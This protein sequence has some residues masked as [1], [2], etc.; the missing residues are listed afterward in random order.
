MAGPLR[1]D[2]GV[3]NCYPMSNRPGRND[4]CP[5]GS[6]KKYKRCCLPTD[7]AA[8]RERARQ[9]ALF[10]DD[11]SGDPEFDADDDGE[12]FLDIEED[13]PI[14]DVD[15]ITRVC[16]TRGFVSKLSDLRSGRGVQVT[17]WEAPQIPQEVLDSIEREAVETLEG[18]WGDPKAADPIQVD[19]IDLETDT[20]VVSIEVFNRAIFLVHADDEE[21]R[22]IH[23]LCGVLEAA[24][25]G[26][27]DQSTEQRG[28]AT[29]LAVIRRAGVS[30]PAAVTCDLASVLK[31]HRRQPGTCD[32]CG[33]SLTRTN[34]HGHARSCALAHDAPSGPEQRLLYL[35]ATASGLPA[36]WVD[37]EARADG[38]L[39]ALDSFLRRL[40]LKCCGH[41]SAFRAIARAAGSPECAA[42]VAMRDVR[43]TGH[44]RLCVLPR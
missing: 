12:E 23:R 34:A 6:G 21:M 8:V 25:S 16:Y 5:C 40:W 11:I 14:L 27:P 2:V 7:E 44:A 10:D 39:E 32:L 4:S 31:G 26:G 19:V 3:L 37:V 36:Y 38:K 20:D 17:E 41:L 24:A 13:A 43:R 35:R 18:E 30:R 42:R 28:N 22:Q 29:P 9:Q 15:A 33:A 1:S